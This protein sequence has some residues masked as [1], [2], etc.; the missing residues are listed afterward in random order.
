MCQ[1]Y[2]ITDEFHVNFIN[3]SVYENCD[4]ETWCCD[5]K[6]VKRVTYIRVG[7]KWIDCLYWIHSLDIPLFI[8]AFNLHEIKAHIRPQLSCSAHRSNML[9]FGQNEECIFLSWWYK[10][11]N[12]PIT[13]IRLPRKSKISRTSIFQ[14]EFT[15]WIML[16]DFQPLFLM[17]CFIFYTTALRQMLW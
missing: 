11:D 14:M 16:T 7:V 3:Q 2:L 8:T 4:G 5:G 17:Y 6:F 10:H 13:H 12:S 1:S 15:A 9:I